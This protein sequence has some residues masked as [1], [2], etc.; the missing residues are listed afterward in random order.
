MRLK[1]E[2]YL[3]DNPDVAPCAYAQ[4]VDLV[5]FC[6][7]SLISLANILNDA[8]MYFHQALNSKRRIRTVCTECE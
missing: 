3:P 7:K 2:C 8:Y 6:E 5:D 1:P 4:K